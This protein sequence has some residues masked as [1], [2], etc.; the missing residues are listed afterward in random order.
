MSGLVLLFVAAIVCL[1]K[2]ENKS[3]TKN[4]P[5]KSFKVQTKRY[6]RV[7]SSEKEEKPI[8]LTFGLKANFENPTQ[9][10]NQ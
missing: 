2:L 1:P 8:T 4:F 10:T 7:K 6:E 3:V 9:T 5:S